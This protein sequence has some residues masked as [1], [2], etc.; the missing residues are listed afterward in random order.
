MH[1]EMSEVVSVMEPEVCTASPSLPL[2]FGWH[3]RHWHSTVRQ[4]SPLHDK[5]PSKRRRQDDERGDTCLWTMDKEDIHLTTLNNR[6]A[7][8]CRV[9]FSA[10]SAPF[11]DLNCRFISQRQEGD[12]SKMWYFKLAER[13]DSSNSWKPECHQRTCCEHGDDFT[14]PLDPTPNL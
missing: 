1:E 4:A 10:L 8:N 3:L 7:G 14:L 13:R 2:A 9:P 11:W 5:R 6:L 12:I